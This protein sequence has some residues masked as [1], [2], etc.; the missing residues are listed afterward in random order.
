M[1]ID[2]KCPSNR[3]KHRK[4]KPLLSFY[5]LS[6]PSLIKFNEENNKKKTIFQQKYAHYQPKKIKRNYL[7]FRCVNIFVLGPPLLNCK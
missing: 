1:K 4:E 6:E 5:Y 2:K 3:K 7:V